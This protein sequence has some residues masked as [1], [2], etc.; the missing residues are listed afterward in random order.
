MSVWYMYS[1]VLTTVEFSSWS[2]TRI[3]STRIQGTEADKL[4]LISQQILAKAFSVV[5]VIDFTSWS[6][7]DVDV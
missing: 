5:I 6:I 2:A 7:Y 4:V 3:L 1:N